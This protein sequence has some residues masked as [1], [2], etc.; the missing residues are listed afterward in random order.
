MGPGGVASHLISRVPLPLD[1]RK[2]RPPAF[3]DI[4]DAK[5]VIFTGTF[6][7]HVSNQGETILFALLLRVL[8]T[9]SSVQETRKGI[10]LSGEKLDSSSVARTLQAAV[11]PSAVDNKVGTR[12]D[13]TD[14]SCD[15]SCDFCDACDENRESTKQVA[16]HVDVAG[17]GEAVGGTAVGADGDAA[18]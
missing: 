4:S 12:G 8:C 18:E 10:S 16:V 13:T 17:T 7:K 11:D 2:Q 9:P 6:S 5:I 14:E 3:L 1:C 15:E